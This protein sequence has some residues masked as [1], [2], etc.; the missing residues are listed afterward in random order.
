M[1]NSLLTIAESTIKLNFNSKSV[2][3]ILNS[4]KPVVPKAPIKILVPKY[5]PQQRN[6][7]KYMFRKQ[8][9]PKFVPYEPY[10]CC[11][12]PILKKK[13]KLKREVVKTQMSKNNVDINNLVEQMAEM[14]ASE[15]SKATIEAIQNDDIFISKAQWETEKGALETDIKNLRETNAH[16][17]NQ[18]KFQAQVRDYCSSS[19]NSFKFFFVCFK[20]NGELKTLLVAAV[21]E[22][23]ETRVQHLTEDKLQLARALLNSANH[24][25][26]HQEQTEWLSGQCEVWRSKFLA[27]SLMVEELARWK[28]ALTQRLHEFQENTKCLLEE[29]KNVLNNM[30]KTHQSLLDV[31]EHLE[32]KT[33]LELVGF[34]ALSEKNFDLIEKIKSILN[35]KCSHQDV[36][37]ASK[38]SAAEKALYLVSEIDESCFSFFISFLLVIAK[39]GEFTDKTR[40]NLFSCNGRSDVSKRWSV[41][42]TASKFSRY[43][44]QTLHG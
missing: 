41:I 32:N 44:L 27:S 26:S 6:Q 13:K 33:P 11:I 14:R 31:L 36:A 17:E 7:N 29:R 39:S 8:K 24:L 15:L 23:L 43:L 16:L 22:D 28:S 25:T 35:V 3:R 5:V 40:C 34:V 37:I 38:P 12:E 4:L 2:T 18:L 9:E 19:F 10:K 1:D 21:G 20:V 42:S 30:C